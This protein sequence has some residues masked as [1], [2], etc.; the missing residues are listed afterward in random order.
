M[1]PDSREYICLTRDSTEED[2][3]WLLSALSDANSETSIKWILESEPPS[4]PTPDA[5]EIYSIIKNIHNSEGCF[6]VGKFKEAHKL[7]NDQVENI[8]DVTKAQRHNRTW[9]A[10]RQ[11]RL[12]AS[13]F[14]AVSKAKRVTPSL[15]KKIRRAI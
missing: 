3:A 6:S 12:T 15:L 4:P 14:G 10:M 5:L 9:Y 8:A 2:K 7:D 1:F 11:G 13:N